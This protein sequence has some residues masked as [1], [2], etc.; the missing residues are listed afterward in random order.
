MA[1]TIASIF[2][3]LDVSVGIGEA[4]R[5]TGATLPQIR[6]WEKKGFIT[7]FTHEDGRNKRFALEDIMAMIYIKELLTQGYTLAK[8]SALVR[9]HQQEINRFKSLVTHSLLDIRET[10]TGETDFTF[11]PLEADATQSLR[12]RVTDDKATLS[13]VPTPPKSKPGD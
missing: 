7:S 13:L 8:A 9:A 3:R 12:A 4:S 1:T 6:Y 10:E 11:G 5:I 2:K